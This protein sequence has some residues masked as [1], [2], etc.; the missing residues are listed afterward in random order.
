MTEPKALNKTSPMQ[1]DARID[2]RNLRDKARF[3]RLETIRLIEIAKVGH[4]SSVF[5]CAEIFASLYYD[6]MHL[7]PNDPTWPGRDRF[8]MGKGHAAVGLFPILADLGYIA[9][10]TLDSYTRLG[11][12][13]G[14][15]PD[16]TKV[17]GIDFSSGSI[18]HALSAGAGMALGGRMNQQDF[19][20]FAMIG[21]GEMQEGQVW[22][23]AMFA[24]H[25][26]LSNLI[27]IVDRNGYQ[28]D[29]KVDDV[30]GV[31][32]V[33]E[34][35]RAFGWQV[36]EVDGHDVVALTKL[37]RHLKSDSTRSTPACVIAK[38]IKGKGVSYMETEPGWHL[39]Y[40]APIDA[41]NAIQEIMSKEI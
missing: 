36:H 23:A 30:M 7:K 5:S 12:P 32:G 20:V 4:Y 22:E 37:L 34:K 1:L 25:Q 35:W 17:A 28:L 24:A 27:C 41:Q 14:D 6:V 9:Q 21:D 10:E 26:K 31:E 19:C 8:L 13:L 3:V 18:G 2:Y 11:S 15:H 16:M 39:G 38:T 40:L 33:A 29:G